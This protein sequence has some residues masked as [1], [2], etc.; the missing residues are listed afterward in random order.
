VC[1][2]SSEVRAQVLQDMRNCVESM[3]RAASVAALTSIID[4]MLL[5]STKSSSSVM[6]ARPVPLV[7]EATFCLNSHLFYDY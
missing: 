6:K 4:A 2:S 3:D 7:N 5:T 1:I